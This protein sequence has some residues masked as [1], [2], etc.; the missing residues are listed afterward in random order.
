MNQAIVEKVRDIEAAHDLA[1]YKAFIRPDEKPLEPNIKNRMIGAGIGA[2]SGFTPSIL[3]SKFLLKKK[4]PFGVLPAI[5]LASAAGG[6]FFPDVYN[7]VLK[8]KQGEVSKEQAFGLIRNVNKSSDNVFSNVQGVGDYF[9]EQSS[10]FL[11]QSSIS[12]FLSQG[13]T[14]TVGGAVRGAGR[15]GKEFLGGLKPVEKSAPL[16]EKVFGYTAKGLALGGLGAGASAIYNQGVRPESGSN[17]KTFLRNNILAG[18]IAPNEVP[19]S[20]IKYVNE[21]GMR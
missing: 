4:L 19:S 7:T 9:A 12:K 13:I 1:G 11:K 20:D 21:L 8:H 3:I 16:G 17:Y 6:Y 5:T 15:L 2:L 14:K 10:D 18:N